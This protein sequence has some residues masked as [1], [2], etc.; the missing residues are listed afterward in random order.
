MSMLASSR[1]GFF[2]VVVGF[3]IADPAIAPRAVADTVKPPASDRLDSWIRIGRD[4]GVTVFTDK[5]D[6]GMGLQTALSQIVAE[7]LDVSPRRVSFVM[8]DTAMTPDQGGVG[9]S[10]SISN[11]ARPLRNAAA[12]A[13][14]LLV[15]LAAQRLGAPAG[16]LTVAD[17]VV[18]GGGK[19]VSYGE[20]VRDHALNGALRVSGRGFN[21]NVEGQ[22]RKST[23]LNSSHV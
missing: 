20:L 10:T 8:G 16:E 7:E 3:S 11:G 14:A 9:G 6:I 17:G 13:R 18:I 12:T 23:R 2:G 22:D 1:R 19:S 4:G 21:V 15:E 5:V